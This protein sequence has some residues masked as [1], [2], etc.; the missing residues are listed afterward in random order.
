[1]AC[2]P[3]ASRRRACGSGWGPP[4][5]WSEDRTITADETKPEVDFSFDLDIDD[6][7]GY[8]QQLAA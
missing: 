3:M 2:Q 5:W 1:M 7:M 6:F 8:L 4:D